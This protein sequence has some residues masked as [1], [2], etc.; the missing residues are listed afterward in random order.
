MT[1]GHQRCCCV[2]PPPSIPPDL[3]S[4]LLN[5]LVDMVDATLMYEEERALYEAARLKNLRLRVNVIVA[6]IARVFLEVQSYHRRQVHHHRCDSCGEVWA[7]TAIDGLKP[8]A[9]DCPKCGQHQHN[10]LGET[11]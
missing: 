3:T 4:V 11:P 2:A 5:H 1:T 6:N 7:H 10:V 8:H 9:H